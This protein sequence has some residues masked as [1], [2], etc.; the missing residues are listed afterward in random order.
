MRKMR[1]P[2]RGRTALDTRLEEQEA[3][4]KAIGEAI[5][6]RKQR[7][8]EKQQMENEEAELCKALREVI[9][10]NE[11]TSAEEDSGKSE[12]AEGKRSVQGAREIR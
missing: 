6:Q 7:H 8:E 4:N 12:A 5:N 3:A 1:K 9:E 2:H 10:V 11:S